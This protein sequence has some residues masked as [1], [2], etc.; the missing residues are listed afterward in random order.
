MV[1][2]TAISRT[3]SSRC[4]SKTVGDA[5]RPPEPGVCWSQAIFWTSGILVGLDK[6]TRNDTTWHV[7]VAHKDATVRG[8]GERRGRLL[9]VGCLIKRGFLQ[10]N[11]Q[12][13]AQ[14]QGCCSCYLD[15]LR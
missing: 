6:V 8:F 10:G 9:G 2:T 1:H 13:Q 14:S 5:A 3:S 7:H 4:C 15:N 11:L 12:S